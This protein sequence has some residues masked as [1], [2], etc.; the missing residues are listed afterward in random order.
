MNRRDI[1][2][3]IDMKRLTELIRPEII[4]EL[5]ARPRGKQY[6]EFTVGPSVMG[7]ISLRS[8]EEIAEGFSETRMILNAPADLVELNN[9][10]FFEKILC[11]HHSFEVSSSK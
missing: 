5:R 1:W 8:P 4:H 3:I 9:M 11:G 7:W 2:T 10:T 6:I